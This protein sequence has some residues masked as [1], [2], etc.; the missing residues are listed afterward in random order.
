MTAVSSMNMNPTSFFNKPKEDAQKFVIGGP[1]ATQSQTNTFAKVG[2]LVPSNSNVETKKF[3]TAELASTSLQNDPIMT[4]QTAP[5]ASAATSEGKA[6]D[7]NWH[8]ASPF[9][10]GFPS[11]PYVHNTWRPAPLFTPPAPAPWTPP[12]KPWSPTTPVGN[13]WNP[14]P[15]AN[16]TPWAGTPNSSMYKPFVHSTE[17]AGAMVAEQWGNPNIT[18]GTLGRHTN[19]LPHQATTATR[20]IGKNGNPYQNPTVHAGQL[21]SFMGDKFTNAR[22]LQNKLIS[23][24]DKASFNDRANPAT[25]GITFDSYNEL[26]RN[27]GTSGSYQSFV[28]IVGTNWWEGMPHSISPGELQARGLSFD[29]NGHFSVSQFADIARRAHF[30]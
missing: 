5:E 1:P 4:A 20:F 19:L 8:T 3:D 6:V 30:G 16:P 17:V 29:H 26:M 23:A 21:N 2:S 11:T 7:P 13:A 24:A 15:V 18:P 12:A 25:G 22:E 9:T 27:A 14:N 10:M 28:N